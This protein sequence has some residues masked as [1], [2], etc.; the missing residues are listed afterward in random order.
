[1]KRF[2]A[3]G[4][5]LLALLFSE[6]PGFPTSRAL[7]A[8]RLRVACTLPV[9]KAIAGEIGG[10]QVEA[11]ALAKGEQDPHFVSPT[12]IL[13][14]KVRKADLLLEIGMQLELWADQVAD[15]SGNSR[16][17]RGGPG[18]V[19]TALGISKLEIPSVIS[20][21]QGD[22]HPEGNPH[23]WLDPVRAKALAANIARALSQARPASADYFASRSADFAMRVDEAFYG[24]ELVKLAGSAEL[25]RHVVDGDLYRFLKETELNGRVLDA[26]AGGWLQR[27]RPL[28]GFKAI[29]YHKVWAYFSQAFG[30]DLVGVIEPFPGIPPGPQQI[31]R[32]VDL[33]RD[34]KVNL[35]LVDNFYEPSTAQGIAAKT[36]AR[37]VVLPSQV[38]GEPGVRT[39][40]DLIDHVLSKLLGAVGA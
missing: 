18:R 33:V 13:M 1:M 19:S 10:D 2:L 36:A 16:L 11:F 34:Q 37:V 6:I 40:F 17:F 22:V 35:I 14:S 29:Q 25:D 23:V 4:T 3:I 5:G 24:A 8:D 38:E 32:I 39:Y 12:P 21:S 31:Q 7:A 15:G 20:R 30:L 28:R 26:A 9:L 27:S